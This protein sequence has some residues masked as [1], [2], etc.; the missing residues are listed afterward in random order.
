MIVDRT[1]HHHSQ[2]TL[3][4]I[5]D[6][7]SDVISITTNQSISISS[8]ILAIASEIDVPPRLHRQATDA[9]LSGHPLKRWENDAD[10]WVSLVR[11]AQLTEVPHPL[12]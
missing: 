11:L 8:W 5:H 2:P 7:L 9:E 4:L 3:T 6:R 1:L 10:D 12:D